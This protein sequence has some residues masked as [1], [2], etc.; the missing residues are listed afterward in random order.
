MAEGDEVH[1]GDTVRV[2][3]AAKSEDPQHIAE[4]I[5]VRRQSRVERQVA[6]A[7]HRRISM[8]GEYTQA[9]IAIATVTAAITVALIQSRAVGQTVFPAVLSDM[10]FLV[11]GFYFSRGNGSQNAGGIGNRETDTRETGR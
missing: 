6:K 7:G 5:E 9:Y 1:V 8:I 10:L 3:D 11:V 2:T 4:A